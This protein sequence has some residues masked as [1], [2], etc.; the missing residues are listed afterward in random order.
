MRWEITE[1][2]KVE[3]WSIDRRGFTTGTHYG[4]G[5]TDNAI[6][7]TVEKLLNPLQ[8]HYITQWH[9]P[10]NISYKDLLEYLV[11]ALLEV[12]QP[13][14]PFEEEALIS[15]VEKF[16]ADLPKLIEK[17]KELAEEALAAYENKGS[18]SSKTI[19]RPKEG[20]LLTAIE[21]YE[22]LWDSKIQQEKD[23]A[24]RTTIIKELTFQKSLFVELI[25]GLSKTDDPNLRMWNYR[26]LSIIKTKARL[27]R[28]VLEQNVQ[29]SKPSKLDSLWQEAIRQERTFDLEKWRLAF[30]VWNNTHKFSASKNFYLQKVGLILNGY[31]K[32][33]STNCTAK[34]YSNFEEYW[35][36]MVRSKMLD[37]ALQNF[38]NQQFDEIKEC[39]Q[40]INIDKLLIT[41]SDEEQAFEI[42]EISAIDFQQLLIAMLKVEGGAS[43]NLELYSLTRE[44]VIKI[45][46]TNFYNQPIGDTDQALNFFKRLIPE[47]TLNTFQF[48]C[49]K[50]D[51]SLGYD[52]LAS[53][54]FGPDINAACVFAYSDEKQHVLLVEG[55]D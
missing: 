46:F 3:Y 24:N 18:T 6:H 12:N 15:R 16:I 36:T 33:I 27:Q 7:Y 40:S 53:P 39:H 9:L 11:L 42:D 13:S 30:E 14:D 10:P 47:D 21:E 26:R 41:L 35:Q 20:L 51:F 38:Y 48:Y 55:A 54:L 52:E 19:K 23:T 28:I 45:S 34:T 31:A 1:G 37:I 22:H 17:G 25:F 8:M 4:S 49:V 2:N 32:L 44:D 50:I 29:N 43:S 5:H